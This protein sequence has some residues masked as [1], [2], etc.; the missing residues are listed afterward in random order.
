MIIIVCYKWSNTKEDSLSS[1]VLWNYF[2]KAVSVDNTLNIKY[3]LLVTNAFIFNGFH[4]SHTKKN[5]KLI[6]LAHCCFSI[7]VLLAE[8]CS[9]GS[10]QLKYLEKYFLRKCAHKIQKRNCVLRWHWV[11]CHLIIPLHFISLEIFK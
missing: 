8:Q 6:I 5:T 10:V 4:N 1:C 9:F 3:I 11:S 2:P 7:A